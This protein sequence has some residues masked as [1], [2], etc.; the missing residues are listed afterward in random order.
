MVRYCGL[1]N[2][3]KQKLLVRVHSFPFSSVSI[4]SALN[5]QKPFLST[6]VFTNLTRGLVETS[7]EVESQLNCRD[8]SL[9]LA[10]KIGNQ[11]RDCKAVRRVRLLP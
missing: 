5:E 11:Q 2:N 6:S 9:L 3:E 10:D 1:E 8:C 4:C 7:L